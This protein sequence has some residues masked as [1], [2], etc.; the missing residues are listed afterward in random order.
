MKDAGV[1]RR[2]IADEL[3]SQKSP[4]MFAAS[5][6]TLSALLQ[7]PLAQISRR[8]ATAAALAAAFLPAVR[9]ANAI[10]PEEEKIRAEAMQYAYAQLAAT[11]QPENWEKEVGLMQVGV[12]RSTLQQTAKLID[13]PLVKSWVADA[14]SASAAAG[15]LNKHVAS[16][17]TFLFLASGA[18]KYETPAVGL[19]Y[20]GQCRGEAEAAL[21][22]LRALGDALSVSVVPAPP[23]PPAVEAPA[24]PAAAS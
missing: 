5:L 15:E 1:R 17:L 21:A 14:P 16:M 6:F 10:A 7:P 13:E 3:A 12:G 18:T 24:E 19:K 9:R 11:L 8:D 2:E 4:R 22:G 20:M 23:A